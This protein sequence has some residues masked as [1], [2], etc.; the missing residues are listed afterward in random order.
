[1]SASC[2]LCETTL[3]HSVVDLG[4]TPLANSYVRPADLESREVFFPLHAR[5]CECCWL[6][7]VP[8][9]ETP[10]A[11]F[12]DYAY[13]SSF[14]DSWVEH[15]RRYVTDVTARLGLN[16]R[17]FV[18]ELASNDGYLLKH[19]CADSIPCLGVE[20]AFNV[21][22]AALDAG[23][24]TV[25]EFFTEAYAH[26]MV[27]MGQSADLVIGNN[28][29]AQVPALR[30]FCRGIE[31]LLKPEGVVTIE[32]PHL[33]KTLEKNEFD[34]VYH[35]HFSYFSFHAAQAAFAQSG[36]RLFDVE[37]LPT[38]GGSLRLFGCRDTSTTHPNT[39]AIVEMI[40]REKAAGLLDVRT[41]AQFHERVEAVKRDLLRFLIEARTAGKTVAAY[42]APAKGNTLL[43]F[44]GIK[45]DFVSY[46]VDR[47]PHKQGCFLPGSRIP[48]YAPEKIAQTKPDYLV[49]LPWNL[50]DEIMTQCA[51]IR[52]WGGRFVLPIPHLTVL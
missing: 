52:Q 19:F 14:S 18:V 20:P 1:M 28:V 7:Q 37:E 34:T 46:T 43:N 33:L 4:L 44:C 8:Q 38:H 41:Y 45:T 35:E 6:V 51:Y 25:S 27:K 17:S 9:F 24:P 39:P 23:I 32:F 13:F 42:G 31:V 22:Q 30:D 40:E 11:I 2:R 15:A 47:N 16:Q 10:D 12:R 5:V 21:A 26:K 3:T 29:L 49:I 36:I 50:S 48:I